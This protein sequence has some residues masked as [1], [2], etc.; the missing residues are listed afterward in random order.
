M[1][2]DK[3]GSSTQRIAVRDS[4]LYSWLQGSQS[5]KDQVRKK[6]HGDQ[7]EVRQA[8]WATCNFQHYPHDSFFLSHPTVALQTAPE[9]FAHDAC[10]LRSNPQR[11][12]IQPLEHRQNVECLDVTLCREL[13]LELGIPPWSI[14]VLMP[15]TPRIAAIGTRGGPRTYLALSA[16]ICKKVNALAIDNAARF[17]YSSFESAHLSEQIRSHRGAPPMDQ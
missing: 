15:I 8:S 4:T 11:P 14:E 7:T 13:D 10:S 16:S 1:Q 5:A 6:R 12:P 3:A 17:V 2:A 9:R